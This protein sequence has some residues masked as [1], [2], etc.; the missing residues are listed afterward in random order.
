MD[1]INAAAEL[2]LEPG[3]RARAVAAAH[4]HGRG[5]GFV[6]QS[7]TTAPRR[8]LVLL[9]AEAG[10]D[11]APPCEQGAGAA[12]GAPRRLPPW[13]AAYTKDKEGQQG[14]LWRD[15]SDRERLERR[16]RSW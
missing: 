1:T 5:Y 12:G 6:Q 9:G 15:T 11:P 10:P 2:K 4:F 16:L 14:M 13:N 7:T 3:A 8:A